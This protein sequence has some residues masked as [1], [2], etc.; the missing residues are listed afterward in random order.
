MVPCPGMKWSG[1][2]PEAGIKGAGFGARVAG[3][4]SGNVSRDRK[5]E[6]VDLTGKV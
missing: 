5:S 1:L 3:S 6:R 2:I 4:E